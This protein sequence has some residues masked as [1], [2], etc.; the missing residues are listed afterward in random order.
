MRCEEKN[1]GGHRSLLRFFSFSIRIV[2]R[3]NFSYGEKALRLG[4]CFG[5]AALFLAYDNKTEWT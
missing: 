2:V 3:I 1:R 5:I 4:Y